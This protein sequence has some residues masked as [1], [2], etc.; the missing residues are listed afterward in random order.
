MAAPTSTA[1]T[2]EQLPTLAGKKIKTRKRDEK[3]KYD[4]TSFADQVIAG[5]N[6]TDGSMEEIAKYL[7]STGGQTDYRYTSICYIWYNNI[8]NF[9][10]N[11][12]YAEPLLDILIAG[13]Q[14]APGGKI[15]SP[16]RVR[17]CVFTCEPMVESIKEHVQVNLQGNLMEHLKLVCF[18]HRL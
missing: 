8:P 17:V 12:R 10:F 18:S 7:D 15:D 2:K 13:G 14:L 11:R 9:F 5:L 4:P 1:S 6:E 3:V 16:V